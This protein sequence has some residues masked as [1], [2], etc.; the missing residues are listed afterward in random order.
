MQ[1]L[2]SML[3]HVKAAKTHSPNQLGRRC[4]LGKCLTRPGKGYMGIMLVLSMARCL[5][6][7]WLEVFSGS[8]CTSWSAMAISYLR[9]MMTHGVPAMIVSYNEPAFVSAE[10]Q[11]FCQSN[12]IQHTQV[13][14]YHLS[15]NSLVERAVRTVKHALSHRQHEKPLLER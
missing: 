15:S 7:K 3:A 11:Q 13:V 12:G 4:I 1:R 9:R 14:P 5:F 10:F 6:S 8:S 2:K